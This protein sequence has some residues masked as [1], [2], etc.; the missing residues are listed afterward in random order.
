MKR[1]REPT[2]DQQARHP[3]YRRSARFG[4]RQGLENSKKEGQTSH[5]QLGLW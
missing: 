1:L 5:R 4:F 3:E 2:K